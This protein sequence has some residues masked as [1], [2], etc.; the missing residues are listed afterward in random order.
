MSRWCPAVEAV[1]LLAV[2]LPLALWLHTPA[3]W[4]LVPLGYLIARKRDLGAYG[5]TL[6]GI[7]NLRFHVALI[8]GVFVPYM[9]GHFLYG[10]QYLG[11]SFAWRL[12]ENFPWLV[13]DHLV[14]V[15]PA[16]EF[17]FRAY[18]QTQFDRVWSARWRVLGATLGPGVILA[19]GIFAACHIFHGGPA[20]LVVFFPGL[21]Y[22]WLWARTRN[23]FVPAFYHGL[24]NVLMSIMLASLAG[25]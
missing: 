18:M 17:F 2:A 12:P 21:L 15:G 9:I 24:S 14:G 3:V 13:V 6:D 5:L 19:A 11:R 16:E 10:T 20:R 8:S 1:G 22:G 25:E 7:P 4:L 23:M